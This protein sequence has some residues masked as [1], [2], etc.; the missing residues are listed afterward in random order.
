MNRSAMAKVAKVLRNNNETPG[1][2]ASFIAKQT[3]LG[4][5]HVLNR[6]SDLR[7]LEGKEIYSNTRKFQGRNKTYY[8][9]AV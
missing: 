7:V 8:R 5:K 9:F 3:G 1:V 6:I 2:T 4:R